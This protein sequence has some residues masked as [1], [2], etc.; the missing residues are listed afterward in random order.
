MQE[1]SKEE[2]VRK[3]EKRKKS[4]L[5]SSIAGFVLC[6]AAAAGWVYYKVVYNYSFTFALAMAVFFFVV[7]MTERSEYKTA[8]SDFELVNED[9][10]KYK[11]V[12][13]ERREAM[14]KQKE[15]ERQR[16]KK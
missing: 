14:K 7:G 4:L 11:A 16:R 2:T 5:F 8:V 12:V 1:L 6:A 13:E 10:E 3:L 15:Y 9:F